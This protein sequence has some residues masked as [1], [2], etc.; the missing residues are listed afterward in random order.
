[1]ARV[2]IGVGAN[3]SPEANIRRG[4][5]LL[6]EHTRVLAISTFYRSPALARPEQADYL[7]GAV[8]IE[9]ELSP[10]D[11]KALLRMIEH[12]LGRQRTPDKLAA[13]PIDLDVLVFGRELAAPREQLEARAFVALPLAELAPELVIPGVGRLGALPPRFEGHGMEG[14]PELASELRR[15]LG[16]EREA[17]APSP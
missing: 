14:L 3:I 7:N 6:A 10:A 15:A 8:A 1:M 16:L 2:V 5:E 17:A 9:T 12:A 4:L 11:L 13:R